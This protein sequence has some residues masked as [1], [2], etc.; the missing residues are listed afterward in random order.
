MQRG[1]LL[2]LL[3][4]TSV[5]QARGR[6][7]KPRPRSN[8]TDDL[9][10]SLELAFILDSS[11]SAKGALFE[12]E[13]RFVLNISPSLSRLIVPGWVMKVRMAVLQYSSIVSMDH[14]FHAWRD[15]RTFQSTVQ[16]MAL[17]GHGTYS[18]YAISNAT[19]MMVSE[20]S[21]D[22]VRVMVL[23]TDGVDHPRNPDILATSMEAKGHG[24]KLFAVGLS[25][26]AKESSGK[27]RSV[28]SMPAQQYVQSLADPQLEQILLRELCPQA[29]TFV[30]EKGESG[31]PGRPGQKGDQGHTGLPGV[32]GAKGAPGIHGRPGNHGNE[33][34]TGYKGNKGERGKCG[35]PGEKGEIGIVG[36]AGIR[37]PKGIQGGL[38]RTGNPG[39]EGPTGQKGDRG[40]PGS[41]GLQ[42]DIGIGFPGHKGEKGLLGRPGPAGPHGIGE[43]GPIG[44]AGPTG[45]QGNPGPPGEGLAGPKG[46]RGYVGIQGTR[47]PPGSGDKGEKGNLG[48]PGI[49]G[50]I[51]A[52]GPGLLGDK[53]D[54]GAA[55]VSGQK[56]SPG[57]GIP[58]PK[59]NQ[60]FPGGPGVPGQRAIGQPGPKGDPGVEGQ[61][62]IPGSQGLDGASGQKG[63]VGFPGLRG[64][65]GAPGK[66]ASGEKGDRGE[67][68]YRGQSGIV[69]PVGPIGP[70]GELGTPGLAGAI[71]PPGRGIPGAKGDPGPSGPAGEVGA[72]GESGTG[73]T[74]DRGPP[75][76]SGP[77]GLSAEGFPGLTGPRGQTGLP[78]VP[79]PVGTGLPGPKGDRGY[80]GPTGPA[81]PPG[82]G[83]TGVKGSFGRAGA[84]GPQGLPGEGIQGPKGE[85]GYRGTPGPRGPPGVGLQGEKGERGFK[86]EYGTA[87]DKGESGEPGPAGPWGRAGQKG[88]PGLTRTDIITIVKSICSCAAVKCRQTPLEL[89]FVIDS[90]ES[91]G[92]EHFDVVKDFVNALVDRASVSPDATRVGVVLYSHKNQVVVSLGEEASDDRVKSAV[93]SMT[94]MGEGTYT[95]SAIHQANRLFLAARRGVRKVA[96]VIT[97]GQ[98]DERDEVRLEKAVTEAQVMGIEMFVIGVVNQSDTTYEQ[99]RRELNLMA[100]DPDDEHVY[101]IKDFDTLSTLE[102]KM[103]T[104][105]CEQDVGQDTGLFSSIPSSGSSPGTADVAGNVREPP[106]RTDTP[107]FTGDPRR[108]QLGPGPPATR[109]HVAPPVPHTPQRGGPLDTRVH[110][111]DQEPSRPPTGPAVEPPTE[112]RR[113]TPSLFLDKGNSIGLP[114]RW[115]VFCMNVYLL[116]KERYSTSKH[117]LS[118]VHSL[119]HPP[120]HP[121]VHFFSAESCR[122]SL[123]PGPCREYMVRWY[124]DPEANACAKFW[125]GGCQGNSNRFETEKICRD[126]CVVA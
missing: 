13:K 95:G 99:F 53:G 10:C 59:G 109:P 72:P 5:H 118:V 71:G 26:V 12:N 78:G 61:P 80:P 92:P 57:I 87:G 24:I 2:F 21:T 33:G 84:P 54:P 122:Q 79:G 30:C 76:P 64:P 105:I 73:P 63:D 125:Y 31:P 114:W 97:D 36:P 44:P 3:L 16:S 41:P 116:S 106:Y 45:L 67:R 66:G 85:T 91:V 104:K 123:E 98:A 27:L 56:G 124:Y 29:E 22:S 90:S 119:T 55:G 51:G 108:T 117:H 93:R 19:Q 89:V 88:E 35:A 40:T 120:T 20:T 62:G 1:V 86:G 111:V 101:L 112:D 96:I 39:H 68:G 34:R 110:Y 49:P 28:A 6:Q 18:S 25:D 52:P 50:R 48:P 46:D 38:G 23:M 43:P 37:G 42:G 8:V 4:L 100:S 75:G 47:G 58:G 82:I 69:G 103:L 15:L 70:K 126:T 74:G 81:G 7:C 107:T 94:Y 115:L 60:G 113:P 14:R 77:A 102:H 121:P 11:E 9:S 83:L 17:I 32:D 65:E